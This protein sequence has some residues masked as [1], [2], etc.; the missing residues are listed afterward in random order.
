MEES[1]Q[2]Q[3]GGSIVGER[4]TAGEEASWGQGQVMYGSRSQDKNLDFIQSGPDPI[5]RLKPRMDTIYVVSWF[6]FESSHL[7]KLRL[8][9]V[10]LLPKHIYLTFA[11]KI[12]GER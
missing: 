12:C 11:G 7:E 9:A 1:N 8:L 3:Y 10:V 2:G 6:C 5:G 4:K